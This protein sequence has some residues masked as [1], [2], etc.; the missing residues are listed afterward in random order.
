MSLLV[1]FLEHSYMCNA[2]NYI[3]SQRFVWFYCVFGW[4]SL[5]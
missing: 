5:S 2:I 3:F 4:L 1:Y